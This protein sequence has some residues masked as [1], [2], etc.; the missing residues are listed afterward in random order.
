MKVSHWVFAALIGIMSLVSCSENLSNKGD[1][2]YSEGK[3][4][5]AVI[6]YDNV[7]KNKPKYVKALYNRGRAYEEMGDFSK[8]E[9]D[10]LAAYAQ[11]TKNTQVLLSLSN[12]YQKQKN[13]NSALLYADAATQVPGAPAMAFFM[14]GRALHQIGSTEDAMK[15]Y[16][17][18]IQIDK[19]FGQAYYYR[20][21]LK[22]AT[23][24]KRSGCED[25]RAAIK[26]DYPDA[27]P[28]LEKYCK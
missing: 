14:K 21:M 26:L 13:H 9:K 1:Q 17:L 25:I 28:A 20:G 8:A 19:D 10:F 5:E 27:K 11:D 22:I 18:A 7:L 2:L 16:S 23:D 6:E 4:Q 3:F 15:E 12:I 24:R